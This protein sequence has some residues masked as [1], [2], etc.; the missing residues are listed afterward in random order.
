MPDFFGKTLAVEE[1]GYAK[2]GLC[3]G[4]LCSKTVPGRVQ[5]PLPLA[6]WCRRVSSL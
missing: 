5:R 2:R 4:E 1:G 3:L 6:I